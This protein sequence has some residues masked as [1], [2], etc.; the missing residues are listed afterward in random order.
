MKNS[1]FKSLIF[2]T[3]ILFFASCKT[4]ETKQIDISGYDVIKE[5]RFHLPPHAVSFNI[6]KIVEIDNKPCL[7]AYFY[8]LS[9]I[10]IYNLETDTVIHKIPLKIQL[11]SISFIN[12]DSIWVFGYSNQN[13]N[14]DSCLMVIN[15]DGI[16]KHNYPLYNPN[17]ISTRY[18]DSTLIPYKNEIWPSTLSNELIVMDKKIFLSFEY[19]YYGIRSYK[20]HYPLVGYYDLNKDSLIVNN[21]IWF[22]YLKEGMYYDKSYY[23]ANLNLNS[24]GNIL[25]SFPYTSTFYEWNYKRNTLETHRVSSQFMDSIMP[26]KTL[27]EDDDIYNIDHPSFGIYGHNIIYNKKENL[28]IRQAVLP[29]KKY[30]KYNPTT[31]LFD[32]SYNYLGESIKKHKFITGVYKDMFLLSGFENSFGYIK[33]VKFNYKPFNKNQ[34]VNQLDS[35]SKSFIEN[36]NKEFCKISGS[37]TIDKS[38][39]PEYIIN[40]ARQMQGIKDT[41]FVLAI[42]NSEAC[43]ACNKHLLQFIAINQ[44]FLFGKRK[45]PFY[46]MIVKELSTTNE[47]KK[48]LESYNINDFKFIKFDTTTTYKQFHPFSF[49]NPRLVLI[50]NNKV[51]S[52]TIYLPNNLDDF[53]EKTLKYYGMSSQ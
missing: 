21:N 33:L 29:E 19:C 37:N 12:K 28:F 23:S 1:F 49:D 36:S 34:I 4:Y 50:S 32:G 15:F 27:F 35:I 47:I 9:S 20:K 25:I 16:I 30:G 11:E 22:P 51:I 3:I 6:A 18:P 46:L 44:A 7:L 53:I 42:I 38:Y 48:T 13:F 26:S 39:K 41:S 8:P 24:K 45:K 14:H 10:Y 17:I 52:D 40:Y 43:P 5:F 2:F 31:I